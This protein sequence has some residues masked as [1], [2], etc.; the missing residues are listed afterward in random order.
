M[1]L[2]RIEITR[3]LKRLMRFMQ[4]FTIYRPIGGEKMIMQKISAVLLVVLTIPGVILD[5]DATATVFAL[6]LAVPMFFS[7]KEWFC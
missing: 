3:A 1:H 7:K 2:M 4:H 6:F 5:G